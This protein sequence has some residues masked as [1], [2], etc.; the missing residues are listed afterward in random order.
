MKYAAIHF[1]NSYLLELLLRNDL[2]DLTKT[3]GRVPIMPAAQQPEF[4]QY[5]AP[6][7]VYGYAKAE[8]TDAY[9]V[10]SEQAAYTIYDTNF[11]RID[12]IVITMSEALN[13]MDDSAKDVNAWTNRAGSPLTGIR[14]GS[15][16][17]ASAQSAGPP[18][19]EGGRQDGLV[20]IRYN[21]VAH[22]AGIITSLV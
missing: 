21:F 7:I 9:F 10:E 1:L 3:G 15:I 22:R 11:G 6:H 13:R 18:G 2:I 8:S 16:H 12:R 5:D 14:F 4:E 17:I 19:E 20:V